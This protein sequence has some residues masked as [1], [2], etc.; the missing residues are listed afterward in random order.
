MKSLSRC[1]YSWKMSSGEPLLAFATSSKLVVAIVDTICMHNTLRVTLLI[2]YQ[3]RP[4]RAVV[5]C[6]D[7]QQQL[8]AG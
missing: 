7:K 5:P 3:A 1:T 6:T 4:R 2:V 8:Q